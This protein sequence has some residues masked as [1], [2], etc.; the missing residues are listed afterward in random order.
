M[1]KIVK[2]KKLS[3]AY[4]ADIRAA[5]LVGGSLRGLAREAGLSE[6]TILVKASRERWGEARRKALERIA[7][8]RQQESVEVASG[9]LMQTHLL[10]MLAVSQRLS[11]YTA[12]LPDGLA[13]NEIA[14]INS[15]DLVAR[16]Q[17]GLDRK[18][19]TV[20]VN[21]WGRGATVAPSIIEVDDCD[22]ASPVLGEAV[23]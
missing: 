9:R 19:P 10:N 11:D 21:F 4:W 3:A 8:Q 6:S 22:S 23:N 16:R 5:Y 2:R 15:L 20:L 18:E 1:R 17:L 14:K 13:F 7:H 12:G